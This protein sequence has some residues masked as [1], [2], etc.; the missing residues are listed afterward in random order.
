[1][2]AKRRRKYTNVSSFTGPLK[3]RDTGAPKLCDDCGKDRAMWQH[4]TTRGEIRY[5]CFGCGGH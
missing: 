5:L 3:H 2:A 4:T 1:M